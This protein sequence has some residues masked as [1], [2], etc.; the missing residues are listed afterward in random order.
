M[1]AAAPRATVRIGGARVTF[2]PDG[3]GRLNPDVLFPASAP[4]G[5][6]TH[7]AYLDDDGRFPV[8]VGAFLVRTHDRAILVDLGLGDVAFGIP[9]V[10][11]FRGGALLDSLAEEGLT[12]DDIDTV[13]YT[14]LH[15]DHV[16]WT[17]NV[18][19]APDTVANQCVTGL[20]FAS[21]RHL[22]AE[23]EWRHWAGTDD[24][25]GPHPDAVQAPLAQHIAFLA[26]GDEVAPG[27]RVL[28]TP[29]HTPGHISLVVT[30]PTGED[31]DRLV[32]LGDVMHCQVQVTESSWNFAFDVD[33][34]Q[35]VATRELLLKELEDEHTLLA[36][37]HFAG[38]VFGRVL[39]PRAV[40]TWQ[41]RTPA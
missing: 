10:A 2:L 34:A 20:T 5:W 26:D 4:D 27:V 1:V 30:D 39:P 21:A 36:G 8:S 14:H 41:R 22:V 19:P 11:D 29:G 12:P 18:A 3:Y 33:P 9:G 7:A 37:G 28:A 6:S 35:S 38:H 40:R 17:T 15:H 23:A 25:V 24:P 16:G 13:V 31:D 32:I